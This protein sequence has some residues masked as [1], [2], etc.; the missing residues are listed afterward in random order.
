LESYFTGLTAQPTVCT[1]DA[2][3]ISDGRETVVA[4]MLATIMDCCELGPQDG[5]EGLHGKASPDAF[6]TFFVGGHVFSP[7]G[8][9]APG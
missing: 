2:F 9:L 6:E 7:N 4:T 8:T 3:A 5:H 1:A